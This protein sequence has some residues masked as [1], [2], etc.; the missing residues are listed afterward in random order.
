M[1]VTTPETQGGRACPHYLLGSLLGLLA[2]LLVLL[3][4]VKFLYSPFLSADSLGL[5]RVSLLPPCLALLSH[6]VPSFQNYPLY[7]QL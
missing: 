1:V 7:H 2:F 6:S 3:P 5:Q 4:L